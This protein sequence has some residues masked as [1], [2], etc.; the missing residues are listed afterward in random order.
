M[1]KFVDQPLSGFLDALASAEPTPGG[2]TAA[3]MRVRWAHRS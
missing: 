2:G 1:P 3:A